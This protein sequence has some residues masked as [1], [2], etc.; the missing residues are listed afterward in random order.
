[1]Y[2]LKDKTFTVSRKT[3]IRGG[4]PDTAL[5]TPEGYMCC[6]GFFCN[7]AGVSED[8]LKC[9]E[10]HELEVEVEGLTQRKPTVGVSI[11][12]G[13]LYRN[14]DLAYDAMQIND[15]GNI[16]AEEREDKL[17]KLFSEHGFTIIFKD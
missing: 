16:S 8:R 5:L 1:M 4:W 12:Y 11:K 7:Q 15:N 3:W 17:T 6:L 13:P 10:P 2:Q 14:T 9:R